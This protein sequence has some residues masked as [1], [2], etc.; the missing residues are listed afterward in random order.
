MIFIP[1]WYRMHMDA[2]KLYT[3]IYNPICWSCLVY[4]QGGG[5]VCVKGEGLGCLYPTITSLWTGAWR[6]SCLL[7][8]VAER[9]SIFANEAWVLVQ[10]ERSLMQ[11]AKPVLCHFVSK[12]FCKRNECEPTWRQTTWRV[13]AEAEI[14]T[15]KRNVRVCAIDSRCRILQNSSW[16]ITSHFIF[17]CKSGHFNLLL[18]VRRLFI[19][20]FIG[21]RVTSSSGG[22]LGLGHSR[23]LICST[24]FITVEVNTL[25]LGVSIMCVSQHKLFQVYDEQV[26]FAKHK[27]TDDIHR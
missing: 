1:L 16:L 24:H 25:R 8:T 20:V 27:P 13:S 19:V 11:L 7:T 22:W 18:K 14:P 4:L 17:Y 23:T 21:H 3:W 5:G 6:P 26:C 2:C 15:R 10:R 12:S 9:G